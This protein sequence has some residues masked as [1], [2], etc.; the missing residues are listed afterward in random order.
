MVVDHDDHDDVIQE[1]GLAAL[2]YY[3]QYKTIIVEMN[4]VDCGQLWTE[5]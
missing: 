3:T 2:E 4:D 1:N 5:D